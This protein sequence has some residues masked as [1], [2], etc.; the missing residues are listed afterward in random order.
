MTTTITETDIRT[1]PNIKKLQEYAKTYKIKNYSRISRQELEDELIKAIKQPPPQETNKETPQEFFNRVSQ[2]TDENELQT[3]CEQLL[4][5]LGTENLVPRSKSNKLRPYGRLFLELTPSSCDLPKELFFPYSFKGKSPIDRHKFFKF[6]GLSDI[7]WDKADEEVRARKSNKSKSKDELADALKEESKI[8]PLDRYIDTATQLL[9]SNDPWELGVG[10]IAVSA[11]R[12]FEIVING[13]FQSVDNPPQY[14][15]YKEYAIKLDGLGKKRGKNPTTIVPLLIPTNE[16]LQALN[17]FRN[18]EEVQKFNRAFDNLIDVGTHE[19]DAWKTLENT[20][21][22]KL[23][24]VTEEYFGFLPKI[25]DGENR[26]NILLRACTLKILT[27]RDVPKANAKAKIQYAGVIAG[28]IIPIFNKDGSV[29]YDGKTN[30]STLNY[31]DYEP[32]TTDIPLLENIVKIEIK[33]TED[34]A[35]IAELNAKIA[36]LEKQ[37]ADKDAEI[38]TLKEKIEYRKLDLPEV[39]EMDNQMLFRSRKIGSG[40]EKLNRAWE[41]ITAYNE[42]APEYKLSPT[43]PILRQLTGVNGQAV[44]KWIQKHEVMYTD[45]VKKHNLDPYYN[46]RYRN[47]SDI[48]VEMILETIEK[49]YLKLYGE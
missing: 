3:E 32:D 42:N 18:N 1:A 27:L 30:A 39:G 41:A 9:N 40:E 36:E 16:F 38:Q 13:N 29:S 14:I 21:G 46:N 24:T 26:K 22:G 7:D 44:K 4:E 43:N 11:R 17:R 45:H 12:P 48:N 6:T 35:K 37:L 2:I 19:S 15:I 33:E 23:R 49:E 25:N 34:M 28:H 20:V 8:F 47:R 31:D 10:L 5:K